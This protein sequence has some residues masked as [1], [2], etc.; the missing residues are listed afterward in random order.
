MVTSELAIAPVNSGA[1]QSHIA[2]AG[3]SIWVDGSNA[4][5]QVSPATVTA[6]RTIPLPGAARTV[7]NR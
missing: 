6:E 2:Y 5:V 3:G 7:L 1:E 4:L